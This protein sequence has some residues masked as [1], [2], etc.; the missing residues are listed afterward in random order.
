MKN[1]RIKFLP[2]QQSVFIAMVY[3]KSRLSTKQLAKIAGIH[4][5]SFIDWRREKLT[6]SLSA[7][8]LFCSQFGLFLPEN[9]DV[10]VT[11]WQ[12]AK[13]EAG[14]RGGINLFKKHGSPATLEGRRKGGIKTMANL[15]RNGIIPVVK[16]YLSPPFNE[17][18]AEYVGIMLGDRGITKVQCAITLNSEADSGYI[19]F[20]TSLGKELF[21][22][23]PKHFYKKDCKAI[24]LYYNGSSL[25]KYFVGIGLKIGNKVKQ[26]VDAQD[27]IKKIRD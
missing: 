6:I 5:R 13:V 2:G 1:L 3:A 8:E 22:E 14:R 12:K 16:I 26:Q 9:R 15:R 19:H 20:V 17:R 18:L 21:G 25:V 10:M 24:T 11:R 7:A 23:D 27:W 4:P